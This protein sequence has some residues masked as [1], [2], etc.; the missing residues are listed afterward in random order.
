MKKILIIFFYCMSLLSVDAQTTAEGGGAYIQNGGKLFNCLLTK[1]YAVNGFGASGTTGNVANCTIEGN[2]YLNG[3]IIVPGDMLMSDGSVHTPQYDTNGN[4]VLPTGYIASNVVG[5][6]FW[7]N[8]NNDFVE[9]K[10]WII[11]VTES[12][13]TPWYNPTQYQTIDIATL[14]NYSDPSGAIADKNGTNNTNSI[15]TDPVLVGKTTTSNCAAKYCNEYGGISGVWF[16]PA[17]GQFREL[18]RTLS[19]VNNVLNKLGYTPIS[20]QYW[21]STEGPDWGA[22]WPFNFNTGVPGSPTSKTSSLQ[23]RAMR[24]INKSN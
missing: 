2:L 20:G 21:S 7:R 16:L 10:A 9:G 11:A 24:I 8:G 6:C 1:N 3:E 13:S 17:L 15:L 14:Y 23:V 19:I 22:A 12:P 4:L 18:N 5:I